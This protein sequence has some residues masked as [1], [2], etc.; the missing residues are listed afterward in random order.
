MNRSLEIMP[1]HLNRSGL[2]RRLCFLQKL[3]CSWG[4]TC[5]LSIS[6]GLKYEEKR[7]SSHRIN[8]LF[9]QNTW[10]P[11]NAGHWRKTLFAVTQCSFGMVNS[12]FGETDTLKQGCR[13]QLMKNLQKANKK[14]TLLTVLFFLIC[15]VTF[16][17]LS[18]PCSEL[19]YEV[20]VPFPNHDHQVWNSALHNPGDGSYFQ[21]SF[22]K[23]VDLEP[24]NVI[25]YT[26]RA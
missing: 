5:F 26:K 12:Q 24:L 19:F 15:C 22:A 17:T 11:L 16:K 3:F 2:F 14:N 7:K 9:S 4:F 10:E 1:K 8:V 6:L 18:S 25:R 23:A 13:F 21:S 20:I